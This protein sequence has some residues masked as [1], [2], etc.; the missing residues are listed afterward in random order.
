MQRLT[1]NRL[2]NIKILIFSIFISLLLRISYLTVAK[3]NDYTVMTDSQYTREESLK[4]INFELVDR[5]GKNVLS[6]DLKYYVV[7]DSKNFISSGS[8]V[9][10]EYI[11]KLNY[12]L[13]NYNINYD[14]EII[15][16]NKPTELIYLE[17]DEIT[18][19]KVEK[20]QGEISGVYTFY[21]NE[22]NR[23]N[24]WAY[25]NMLSTMETS[26]KAKKDTTSIE[27]VISKYVKDNP[28]YLV[29]YDID[30]NG[31]YKNKTDNSN[32]NRNN[33]KLTTDVDIEKKIYEAI[34]SKEFEKFHEIGVAI[35]DP[36]TGEILAMTQKNPS[37][38]NI[39]LGS[40]TENGYEPASIF[41]TI[42][43][44]TAIENGTI[45]ID[46][47]IYSEDKYHKGD[48]NMWEAF[49]I[50]SNSYYR[51]LGFLTGINPV[52]KN[53]KNMGLFSKVLNFDS[54]E[55]VTGDIS[56]SESK[57]ETYDKDLLEN[58]DY[59]LGDNTEN[60][61]FIG[62]S[63]RISPLQAL[64]IAGT[65]INDGVFVKPYLLK[66]I[67]NNN[68]DIVSFDNTEVRV[69]SESTSE[70][71][72]NM[73]RNVVLS[74]K[75]TAKDLKSLRIDVGGKT[76]TNTRNQD[77]QSF[78][79]AWFTGFFKV[80]RQYYTI[81]VFVKGIDVNDESAE[82]TAVPITKKVIETFIK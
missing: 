34:N 53:A 57:T 32:E 9:K 16:K 23:D 66:S 72:K 22:V 5:N 31:V 3:N 33:V 77:N 37:E 21:K 70:I 65:I 74:N 39:L 43:S 18:Y 13:R 24:Y 45:P 28:P 76:G 25:P 35:A 41:K 46:K 8:E 52:L 4:N 55:E 10:L 29:S 71:M 73:M 67:I 44:A 60:N 42:V 61:L 68:T 6:F 59:S 15:S 20:I 81:V 14:I 40:S 38:P 80:D 79:D 75:G 1:K 2:F 30:L 11:K 26:E 47:K 17:V 36:K 82:N 49:A 27:G 48:Y 69:F 54:V 51:Q 19:Q 78:S 7:I 62:Q 64:G 12:I 58:L 56:L 50:S 63:M